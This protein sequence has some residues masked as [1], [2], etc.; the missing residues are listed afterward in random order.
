LSKVVIDGTS[1]TSPQQEQIQKELI[2]K[3]FTEEQ[4]SNIKIVHQEQPENL[5]STTLSGTSLSL[6]PGGVQVQGTLAIQIDMGPKF[7]GTMEVQVGSGMNLVD[8]TPGDVVEAKSK[9]E[10]MQDTMKEMLDEKK[11]RTDPKP[12]SN[13]SRSGAEEEVLKSEAVEEKEGSGSAKQNEHSDKRKDLRQSSKR[14]GTSN[15]SDV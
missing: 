4:L 10:Q 6:V 8:A 9:L 7:V 1:L 2:D 15:E 13:S 3:G 5:D 11:P 12:D 14:A